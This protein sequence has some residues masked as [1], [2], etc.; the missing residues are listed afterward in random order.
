MIDHIRGQLALKTPTYLRVEVNGIGYGVHIP[1]STYDNLAKTGEKIELYTFLHVREDC[2]QLFGF[3]TAEEKEIFEML[4]SV[5]GVGPRL[6]LRILSGLSVREFREA[7][8]QE[9]L[10]L[11]TAIPGVGKKTAQRLV[12]ELKEK[13]GIALAVEETE[14]AAKTPEEARLINDAVSA[15]LSLG[16]KPAEATKAVKEAKISLPDKGSSLEELVKDALK[17]L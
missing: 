16:C 5:S 17:H 3:K 13:I 8:G 9:N 6:A 12:I 4:V 1:L 11:L 15:L 7:I 14:K 2:L 10:R